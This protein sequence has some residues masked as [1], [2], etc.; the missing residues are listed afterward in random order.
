MTTFN[1][2]EKSYEKKFAMD[3][4]KRFKAD[5]RRNRLLA[6]W[7]AGRLG[8]TGPA[9]EDYV[10]AVRKADLSSKGDDDVFL[11][12]KTDLDEK[13]VGVP[14]KELRKVMDDFL[15]QAAREIQAEAKEKG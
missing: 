5:A 9:A 4:E 3:E 1:E 7:A 12:V 2:R 10:K 8:L 6:H 11:K 13:G 14:D 15:A